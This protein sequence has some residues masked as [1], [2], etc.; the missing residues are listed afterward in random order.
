MQGK[1]DK[2]NK[3]KREEHK[4]SQ[5][6]KTAEITTGETN[7]VNLAERGEGRDDT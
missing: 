7:Y 4:D 6:G 3:K 2:I 5:H 1:K